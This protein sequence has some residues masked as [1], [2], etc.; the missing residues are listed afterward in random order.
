MIPLNQRREVFTR[1]DSLFEESKRIEYKPREVYKY[2]TNMKPANVRTYLNQWRKHKTNV[3]QSDISKPEKYITKQKKKKIT[4]TVFDNLS[5][6]PTPDEI[7]DK[8]IED[9]LLVSKGDKELLDYVRMLMEFL[10]KRDK[11]SKR[12]ESLLLKR[13]YKQPELNNLK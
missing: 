7:T 6:I 4:K 11:F 13:V 8:Y 3:I 12:K 5:K 2:F 9:I 1:M 10:Y